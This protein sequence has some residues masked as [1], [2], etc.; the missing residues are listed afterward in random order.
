MSARIWPGALCVITHPSMYGKPVEALRTVP[1]GLGV[2]RLPDG[3]AHDLAPRPGFWLC[4]SQGDLFEAPIS[5][6]NRRLTRY[7]SIQEYWLKP[8]LPPPDAK[9]TEDRAPCEVQPV[10]IVGV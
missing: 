8:L 7:A 6:G 3:H 9:S 5:N 2:F 4:E 1:V 10:E